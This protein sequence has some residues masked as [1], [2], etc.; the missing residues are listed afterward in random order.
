[1]KRFPPYM[2]VAVCGILFLSAGMVIITADSDPTVLPTP[3]LD[4]P[5]PTD[6]V[7]VPVDPTVQPV[8]PPTDVPAPVE[9]QAVVQPTDVV[10]VPVVVPTDVVQ[11]IQPTALVEQGQVVPTTANQTDLQQQNAP[12]IVG[13]QVDAQPTAVIEVPATAMP[14]DNGGTVL[15][16][17]IEQPS[18]PLGTLPPSNVIATAENPVVVPNIVMPTIQPT[19]Q[20]IP[21]LASLSQVTGQV[22]A[23]FRS[24]ASGINITLTLPDGTVAQ[25][26]TDSA[27]QFVFAN[28]APGSYRV[29]T[30]AGGYLSSQA[31]FTLTEGQAFVLPSVM[32]VGGDTNQDNKIDLTDAALIAANFDTTSVVAGADLNHD[33]IVDIRDLTAIGAYFGQSGPI[34]WNP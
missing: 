23:P 16:P 7:V 2:I 20:T 31:A 33:R 14:V 27:G 6:I 32:L 26:V 4:V 10:V 28:L 34:A 15:T 17:V 9:V 29:N 1:M 12:V 5:T 3:M 25:T 19:I 22:S 24:D 21:T 30:N 11:V 13:G 8:V 18:S